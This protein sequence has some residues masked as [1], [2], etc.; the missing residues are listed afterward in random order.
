MMTKKEEHS[1][2]FH[3]SP[4]PSGGE[5]H[6]LEVSVPQE[7]HHI[8]STSFGTRMLHLKVSTSSGESA[9]V[10]LEKDMCID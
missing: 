1:Q 6:E 5:N 4:P 8:S 7:K 2:A 9:C 10:K 3:Q